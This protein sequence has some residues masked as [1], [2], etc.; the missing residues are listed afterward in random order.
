MP[1]PLSPA[2]PRQALGLLSSIALPSRRVRAIISI[3]VIYRKKLFTQNNLY[4]QL[5]T[6]NGPQFAAKQFQQLCNQLGVIHERV[7]VKTPT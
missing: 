7:P 5:R 2:E 6:D 4:S 3:T 1:P